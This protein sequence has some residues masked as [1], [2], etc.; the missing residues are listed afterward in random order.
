MIDYESTSALLDAPPRVA[1]PRPARSACGKR[2]T[3][4][5]LASLL[6]LAAAP[7]V[8]WAGLLLLIR[9]A[10]LERSQ[11]IGR[12]GRVFA[13][14]SLVGC[15]ALSAL[16]TLWNVL[17]GDMSLVGPRAIAL[18]DP[19]RFAA[20]A[21]RRYTVRPGL[22]STH[23]VRRWANIDFADELADDL[24]Y[25]ENHTWRRDL[26]VLAR[27]VPLALFGAACP[28][29][30]GRATLLGL[31]LDNLTL[32]EAV[33]EIIARLDAHAPSQVCFVNADCV[34]VARRDPEYTRVLRS[35]GMVLADGIGMR[36]AGKLLG[37]PIRQNVNGT[38][39]FPRLCTALGRSGHRV[40]LLGG[41]PGVPEA[42]AQ[43]I[44][45][46]HPDVWI[47]GARNGYF[48]AEAEPRVV[49]EI[50]ASGAALVLVAFGEPKQS[51]WIAEHLAATGAAVG[52]GVGGLF[53]FY[54]GRI[55]RA[56]QW[57]RELGLEWLYRL[58]REP[59]RL[60]KRYVVGNLVFLAYAWRARWSAR[61]SAV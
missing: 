48:A 30:A 22:V 29:P 19:L 4:V 52:I 39:L 17:R 46:N 5:L 3:D 35:A 1:P 14:R 41:Q 53:D 49:D 13:H 7:L 57:L 11:R 15:R 16:P 24:E 56:P 32:D 33:G 9:R 10:R 38:D 42:V 45:R 36:L 25:V 26:G 2:A 21:A 60:W 31:P 47:A 61:G 23:M 34:N 12:D 54:S 40:F 6:L 37:T 20:E 59:R 8:L 55:P 51:R 18:D 44:G 43:W 50:R 58:W 28:A 27:A